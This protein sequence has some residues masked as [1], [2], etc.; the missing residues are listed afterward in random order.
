MKFKF[1]GDQDCPEWI[2]SEMAILSKLSSVRVRLL[3]KQLLIH[4]LEQ[5]P[6]Y[7]DKLHKYANSSRVYI[8]DI[9]LKAIMNTINFILTN[10]ARFKINA[11]IL[12]PELEQ[13]GLPSDVS[14]SL[15]KIYHSYHELLLTKLQTQ[16][17]KQNSIDSIHW[18]VNYVLDFHHGGDDNNT[19]NNTDNNNTTPHSEARVILEIKPSCSNM[20]ITTDQIIFD[21][22]YNTIELLLSELIACQQVVARI[23]GNNIPSNDENSSTNNSSHNNNSQSLS[24]E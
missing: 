19:D 22:S 13:L 4:L 2:L 17:L 10:A 16:T 14:R 1:C 18:R 6:L 3:A 5:T 20:A 15:S 24:V 7:Y 21:A 23:T 11:E 12:Y 8:D 9:E